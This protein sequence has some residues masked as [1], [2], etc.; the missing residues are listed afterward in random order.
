VPADG[1][2]RSPV[3]RVR[4]AHLSFGARTLWAGLDLSL[5]R[6]EFLTVLGANG[7]GKTSLLRSVLGLQSLTSGT[8][9]VL[10]ARSPEATVASVTSRSSG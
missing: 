8:V 2:D 4:D 5:H 10:V 9:E 6:G 1:N 7:S 3:L